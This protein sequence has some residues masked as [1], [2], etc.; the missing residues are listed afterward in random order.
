MNK[1]FYFRIKGKISRLGQN[2]SPR[3]DLAKVCARDAKGL[4]LFNACLF[5][6]KKAVASGACS[7]PTLF[8]FHKKYKGQTRGRPN[9]KENQYLFT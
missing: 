1:F 7:S 6:V 8:G 9:Y 2:E 3:R 4:A 5:G